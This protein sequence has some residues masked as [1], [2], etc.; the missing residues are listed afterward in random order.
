MWVAFAA[1]E[2][3]EDPAHFQIRILL[4]ETRILTT[5]NPR[6]TVMVKALKEKE[7]MTKPRKAVTIFC[8]GSSLGNGQVS[9]RAAAVAL[10]GYQGIWRAV[11]AYLGQA[12]NQQAEVAAAALGLESL[13]EPCSVHL[14]TDSRYVVETM[15][16]RFRRKAN[17]E[18]WARLDKAAGRHEVKWEWTRGHDGNLVQE[19]A[20]KAARRIAASG[21]VDEE[22]LRAAIDKIGTVDALAIS[23]E[24]D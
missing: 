15:S 8:D 7:K 14:F 3:E 9:M 1:R 22:I 4:D 16:G 12:T 5:S 11:G 18:W 21:R 10:L 17:H 20:D 2:V 23:A 13:R 24:G 6:Y 19:A